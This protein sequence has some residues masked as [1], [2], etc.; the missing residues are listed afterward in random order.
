[1]VRTNVDS[2]SRPP[3]NPPSVCPKCGSHRTDVVGMSAHET[4][5]IRCTVC[6]ERST[7][8]HAP[9]EAAADDQVEAE[10]AV[11]QTIGGALSQL[12]DPDARTRV[13]RWACD[14]F[15]VAESL[16]AHAAQA[17]RPVTVNESHSD[18]TMEGVELFYEQSTAPVATAVSTP[19]VASV[20][21]PAA[22]PGEAGLES[23]VRGF[24]ND[25]QQVALEWQRA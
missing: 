13:L 8:R 15:H 25:F 5:V 1:M 16:T 12:R 19:S 2:T 6:G 4:W 18:L 24:V 7:V 10:L 11:M 20:A 14:R 23:M 22:P 9:I 17:A 3:H 21:S